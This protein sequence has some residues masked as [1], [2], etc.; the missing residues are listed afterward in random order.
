MKKEVAPKSMSPSIM[1]IILMLALV[2]IIAAHVGIT[3]YGIGILKQ[4]SQSV[5]EAVE[6][7]AASQ[8]ELSE[9]KKAESVL[10]TKTAYIKASD[11][12]LAKV[13]DRAYQ[14]NIIHDAIA[15]G[16]KSGVGVT[17]FTFGNDIS[18][19]S[20]TTT[21]SASTTATNTTGKKPIPNVTSKP[22]V[23]NVASPVSYQSFLNL[24]KYL[25]GNLTQ[26]HLQ[27][28]NISAPQDSGNG[29]MIEAP[30]LN[31]EVYTKQ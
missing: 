18:V 22:V 26:I 16:N 9:L 14:N 21:K 5:T 3:Y 25:E 23:I 17:G 13:K 28:L 2:F 15:Y 31:I 8:A 24:L 7:S 11:E 30:A 1:R 19:A 29:N 10:K 4:N 6:S 12:L 27:N 20:T